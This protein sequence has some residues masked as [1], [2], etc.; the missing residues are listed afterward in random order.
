MQREMID[1]S[2]VEVHQRRY[3]AMY[4]EF[5]AG[6]YP[7]QEPYLMLDPYRTAP[8]SAQLGIK[9]ETE[10]RLTVKVLGKQSPDGDIRKT[11]DAFNRE[12]FVPL[13]GLY[14]DYNNQVELILEDRDGNT[15]STVIEIPTAPLPEGFSN[16]TIITPA[17]KSRLNDELYFAPMGSSYMMALDYNGEVRWYINET[18]PELPRHLFGR[19]EV[20]PLRNGQL[21]TRHTTEYGIVIFTQDGRIHRIFVMD[22]HVHHDIRE[23]Q[24]GNLLIQGQDENS[25]YIYDLLF[26][27]DFETEEVHKVLDYKNIFNPQGRVIQPQQENEG[28]LDSDWW[29]E[30]SVDFHN[31]TNVYLT[32]ARHQNAVVATDQD[33]DE[34]RWILGS[35]YDWDEEYQSYLLTPVDENG[36][37]LYDFANQEERIRADHEFWQWAQHSAKILQDSGIDHIIDLYLFDN[38]TFRSYYE[39]GWIYTNENYSRIVQYRIDTVNM[40]VQILWNFGK[41][42]GQDYYSSFVSNVRY[43]ADTN[44]L[45]MFYGGILIDPLTGNNLGSPGTDAH[46]PEVDYTAEKIN[47]VHV[48]EVAKESKE[49]LFD[50]QLYVPK[51]YA[52]WNPMFRGLKTGLYTFV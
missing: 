7:I 27:M 41:D 5:L 32:S 43:I 8:L 3:E 42:L 31:P 12:H 35:H 14:P 51:E 47:Y 50:C 21:M 36:E 11:F 25:Y 37:P 38:G 15:V 19:G 18:D 1:V 39:E 9:T 49:I 23:D 2:V 16:I 13:C 40:T 4:Q 44:S 22:Y 20:Y 34:I 48:I 29:H 24:D 17:D 28:N 45:C 46:N 6:Q 52:E 33:T 26:K 30:N 10:T